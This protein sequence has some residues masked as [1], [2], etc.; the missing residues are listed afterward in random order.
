VK[1]LEKPVWIVLLGDNKQYLVQPAYRLLEQH[2]IKA[3]ESWLR[4]IQTQP[5]LAA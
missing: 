2:Q 4:A 1:F 3:W 5:E